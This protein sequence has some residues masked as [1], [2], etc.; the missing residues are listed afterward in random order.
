MPNI[1]MKSVVNALPPSKS[2]TEA[3]SKLSTGN[4]QGLYDLSLM[5]EHYTNLRDVRTLFDGSDFSGNLNNVPRHMRPT[6]NMMR[7]PGGKRSRRTRHK[8]HT[9][10]KARKTRRHTRRA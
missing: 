7:R 8:K 9:L 2:K 10:R 5:P 3:L 1:N 6:P 4:V